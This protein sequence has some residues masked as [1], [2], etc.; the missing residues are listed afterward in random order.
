MNISALKRAVEASAAWRGSLVGDPNPAPLEAF[1]AEIKLQRQAVR[2]AA[3]MRQEHAQLRETLAEVTN[4]PD[5][6]SVA[7][8]L[9][10]VKR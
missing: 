3:R 1:D 7:E 2:D 4:L 9:A 10:K 6:L 8:L 5:D